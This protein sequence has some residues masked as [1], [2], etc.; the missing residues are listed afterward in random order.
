MLEEQLPSS[1]EDLGKPSTSQK[2]KNF[3]NTFSDHRKVN[4]KES[5]QSLQNVSESG[6]S[7]PTPSQ[8]GVYRAVMR[9]GEKLKKHFVESLRHENWCLHFDGKTIQKK[10][11]QVVVL[12]NENKEIRLAVVELANGK[13]K[14]IFDG[15]KAILDE[16]NLWS[17]IKMIV[18]DTTAANTGKSLGAVT[19]LK[20]HFEHTG[21][22][23]PV[24]I[25]CQH[26]ILDTILKHVLNDHFG[27]TPTSPNLSYPFIA[28]LTE[29]YA[30]LKQAFTNTGKLLKK[31]ECDR[32]Q[33]DMA[34]LYHL[35]SCYKFFKTS[36]TFP[37]VNFQ[38]LPAL[39]NARWNSRAIYTLLAFI[40]MP[41]FQQKAET[42]CGFI[43]GSWSDIWFSAQ[44]FNPANFDHLSEACQEHPKALKFLRRY[45]SREPTPIPTQRS[46][47]CAER[48]IKVMQDLLPLCTST[49]RLNNKF[50]LTNTQ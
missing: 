33:D 39:S 2:T 48:A 1:D 34:F 49:E 26:H 29:E 35:I 40:L 11:Y 38:S 43:I 30:Q 44:F 21:Q 3:C 42:A 36:Q 9:K 4:Y 10:E 17:S 50:L 28:R 15:I 12:K 20:N 22:E 8:S 14:T 23:K 47:I 27:E 13:G 19:L 45:W 16:Y 24:F 6:V 18:S 25:G 5:P 32:W 41:E 46:N 7:I 31:T 37:K